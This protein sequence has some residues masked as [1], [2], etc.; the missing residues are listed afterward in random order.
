MNSSIGRSIR[1]LDA[2]EK[3]RGEACYG[4]DLAPPGTLVAGVLRSEHAHAKILGMDT[5]LA[6]S[7]PGVTAVYTHK[8]V[9]GTNTHGLVRQD[10]ELLASHKVRY[11]GDAVALV[12]VEF[13]GALRKALSLIEVFYQPLPAIFNINDALASGAPEVHPGGNV[14]LHKKLRKGDPERAFAKEAEVVVE[15]TWKTHSLDHAFLDTEAGM[16]RMEEDILTI[17]ASGQWVHEERRILALALGLPVEKIRIVQ[18]VTGGAFGGREDLGI[19]LYLGLATLKLG[20][21][22]RLQYSRKDSMISR[23]KRHPV[24][25]HYKLGARRDGTLVAAE[26]TAYADTGAYASTGGPVIRK[27]SS[28]ATGPYRVP[29]IKADAYAVYT[30]NNPSGAMRGFGASQTAIAYEG[31]MDLLAEKL[32]IDRVELRRKNLVRP[33]DS[34]T[35]GQIL[36]W[37]TPIE[38]LEEAVA[39]IGRG[40]KDYTIPAPHLKRG[41]GVST[42]CFGIG[43]GDAFPDT[44][45]AVVRFTENGVLEVL[46][47][48][49]E[50]GQGLI[51]VMAQIAAEELG[52]D[53]KGVHVILADT[54]RTPEAGS[55]SASRQTYT[56][57]SAVRLAAFELKRKLMDIVA[58]LLPLH[59]DSLRFEKGSIVTEHD[60]IPIEKVI[61]EGRRR[62][63]V[64]EGNS[65]FQ[66][67]TVAGDP[68]TGLSPQAFA[69]YLF[70]SH[71]AQVLVDVYT[72]EV[73]VER[74]VAV[75]DVGKAINPQQVSGQI[76]GG[77]AMGLG[78]ALMEEVVRDKGEILNP[79]F[80]GYLL[81]TMT[82]VPHIETVIL[83][84]ADPTGPYG[85]RGIGEPPLIGTP[86]AILSAIADAIGK[87][88]HEVPATPERVWRAMRV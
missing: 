10:Q 49:V 44:S 71:V 88:I 4:G 54:H 67:P 78:M 38:C 62:G 43:Y 77:V 82:D 45:R 69:T 13:E 21:P 39:H 66:P 18:P 61:N 6:S 7:V 52:V 55:T 53:P 40:K 51:T 33:G 31:A 19:Q 64:L 8:D 14:M 58:A 3:V 46:T 22:V 68:E 1:R 86:P 17:Y 83:E 9:P 76:A 48:A 41:Y 79:D 11:R 73:K 47:G 2:Q 36:P 37:A 85:A 29:H 24:Q 60:S 84:N 28:H 57:G 72:G 26:L 63:Y 23:H 25:L 81:P 74:I 27:I 59:P 34:V 35:T 56:T 42:V 70:A 50:M 75:H 15:G 30:N 65:I 20:K 5:S 12:V 16:A 32:G 87:P 80:S